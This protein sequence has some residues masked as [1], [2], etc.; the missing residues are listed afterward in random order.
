MSGYPLLIIWYLIVRKQ[1]YR[2][3]LQLVNAHLLLSVLKFVEWQLRYTHRVYT[4]P[5]PF[6]ILLL[7]Y[8]PYKLLNAD[9]IHRRK[10]DFYNDNITWCKCVIQS[11]MDYSERTYVLL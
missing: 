2:E 11:S 8:I 5:K 6:Y 4:V 3:I 10:M 1:P 7:Q 9:I